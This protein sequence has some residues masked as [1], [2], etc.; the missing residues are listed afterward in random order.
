MVAMTG[1]GTNGRPRLGP[2]RRRVAMN[3]R[4]PGRAPRRDNMV[5]LDPTDAR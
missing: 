5:A 2:G 1:D 4:H 3:H